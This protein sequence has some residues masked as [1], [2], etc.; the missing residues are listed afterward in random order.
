MTSLP[1]MQPGASMQAMTN[2]QQAATV[3]M[4]QAMQ[5]LQSI[6][7][8]NMNQLTAAPP[9]SSAQQAY[10]DT[11]TALAMQQAAVAAAASGQTFNFQNAVAAAAPFM[12]QHRLA[13]AGWENQFAP[14]APA[15]AH[16]A[17]TEPTS[18]PAPTTA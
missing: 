14:G 5:G 1:P 6:P 13:T 10:T 8:I 2:F 9:G 4:Q 15:T 3:A 18:A 17:S 16:Q 12:S 7:G 11:M